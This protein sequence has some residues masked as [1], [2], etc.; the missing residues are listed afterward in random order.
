M[1]RGKLRMQKAISRSALVQLAVIE[2]AEQL[3]SGVEELDNIVDLGETWKKGTAA[4]K[5]RR[6]GASRDVCDV[7]NAQKKGVQTGREDRGHAAQQQEAAQTDAGQVEAAR[8]WRRRS[9]S[10]EFRLCLKKWREFAREIERAV[11]DLAHLDRE[12]RKIGGA[13]RIRRRSRVFGS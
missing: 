5:K 4:D 13:R 2:L 1:E 8:W 10:G 6:D 7:V 9:R 11:E 3:K 12:I